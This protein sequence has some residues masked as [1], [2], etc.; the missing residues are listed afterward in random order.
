VIT[1]DSQHGAISYQ[2]RE[3]LTNT[4]TKSLIEI[5][6]IGKAG[7]SRQAQKL[8]SAPS[9][10]ED[11]K[12]FIKQVQEEKLSPP[13]SQRLRKKTQDS[14]KPHSLFLWQSFS[15]VIHRHITAAGLRYRYPR[16]Q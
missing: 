1:V 16:K 5:D 13:L 7:F 8:P 10:E 14:S 4:L 2:D 9:S 12:D 15:D 6:Q 11:L 3:D